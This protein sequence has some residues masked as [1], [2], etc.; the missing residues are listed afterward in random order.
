M[1]PFFSIEILLTFFYRLGI[2]ATINRGQ[3]LIIFQ[4]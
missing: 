1:S 4:P 2:D 3:P